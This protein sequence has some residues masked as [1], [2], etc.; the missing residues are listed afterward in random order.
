MAGW[1][2]KFTR[3][4]VTRSSP[5]PFRGR[6]SQAAGRALARRSFKP[7]SDWTESMKFIVVAGAR[8]NFIKIA[9]VLDAFQ[10]RNAASHGHQ[11]LLVHTGQHYDRQMSENF[12]ADLQIPPPDINLGV[13]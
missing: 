1:S 10:T 5:F 6:L 4:V 13:G 7:G 12:F 8:P 11:V 9:S 3:R 2:G